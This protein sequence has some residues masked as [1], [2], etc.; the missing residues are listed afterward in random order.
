MFL[1]ACVLC[2]VALMLLAF[3]YTNKLVKLVATYF[4]IIALNLIVGTLYLS[5]VSLYSAVNDLDYQ[6][7]TWLLRMHI[8]FVS[9][10]RLF[11]AAF[12]CY[13]FATFIF[14]GYLRRMKIYQGILMLL[15][16]IF[17][18]VTNDPIVGQ[19][20]HIKSYTST[21]RRQAIYQ[22]LS[23]QIGIV[24]ECIVTVYMILPVLF[25]ILAYKK[26]QIY[27]KKRDAVVSTACVCIV[28][29][30]IYVI[31]I[32][33]IYAEIMFGN[34]NFVKI[35][36]NYYYESYNVLFPAIMWVLVGV[37][38][39]L[40]LLLKPYDILSGRSWFAKR[41]QEKQLNNNINMFLHSYKN[42]FIGIS[43]RLKLVQAYLDRGEEA[44]ACECASQ[45]E[46]ITL[47]YLKKINDTLRFF[48]GVHASFDAVDLVACLR[49]AQ[50]QL[51]LQESSIQ[52]DF[53][54]PPT[55]YIQGDTAHLTECFLNIL[56]NAVLAIQEKKAPGGKITITV[57]PEDELV[58]VEIYDNGV[59]IKKENR[60]KVFEPFFSI[61][62]SGGGI[63]LS[64]VADVVKL[65]HGVC[66]IQS[67]ENHYTKVQMVF[68]LYQKKMREYFRKK[69]EQVYE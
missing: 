13:L 7:Y 32:R 24:N 64:Y 21:G 19:I 38:L 52:M 9:I 6:L 69:R 18:F 65:H 45:G 31:L 16:P 8:P 57:M 55:V 27:I 61:R 47:E 22:N 5:R 37:I 36:M 62:S 42:A 40:M 66:R 12:S 35:P 29:I 48:K 68:P 1:S 2:A 60:K 25:M 26:T 4:L 10:V 53:S 58:L 56:Q 51:V 43:Q 23:G 44:K 11:N 41:R 14:I 63:G 3:F 49:E 39:M 67:E 46:K 17:F 59:G 20:I 28:N 33:G 15:A 50:H 54:T 34:V 30:V